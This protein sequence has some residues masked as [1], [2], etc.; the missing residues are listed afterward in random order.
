M[1]Q[2]NRQIL[3]VI[4]SLFALYSQWTSNKDL[5]KARQVEYQKLQRKFRK[6][7]KDVE[8]MAA[9]VKEAE[10]K[11]LGHLHCKVDSTARPVQLSQAASVI[12]AST[13]SSLPSTDG[14]QSEAD[15]KPGILADLSAD[16]ADG[17]GRI[18]TTKNETNCPEQRCDNEP[19]STVTT[20]P[21]IVP[22]DNVNLAP[23]SND[24]KES[25]MLYLSF[26]R[27]PPLTSHVT[28]IDDIAANVE[29]AKTA[30]KQ[31]KERADLVSIQSKE[32]KLLE[33]REDDMSSSLRRWFLRVRSLVLLPSK[34]SLAEA[35]RPVFGKLV[36][37]PMVSVITDAHRLGISDLPDVHTMIN[38]FKCLSW[39]LSTLEVIGRK[40]SISEISALVAMVSGFKLPDEKALKTLK[41]MLSRATQLQARIVKAV[42]SKP[43]ET[44]T[45]QIPFLMELDASSDEV[46]LIIPEKQVLKAAINDNGKNSSKG[47]S[48]KQEE[49]SCCREV[50]PHAPDHVKLWPPFGVLGSQAALEALGKECSAIPDE[51]C[52]LVILDQK[53]SE[54]HRGDAVVTPSLEPATPTVQNESPGV[55]ISSQTTS[56]NQIQVA[57]SAENSVSG[58]QQLAVVDHEVVM[59]TVESTERTGG[60]L[61]GPSLDTA[62]PSPTIEIASWKAPPVAITAPLVN[63]CRDG[64]ISSTQLTSLSSDIEEAA[65]DIQERDYIPGIVETLPS[66]AE[67]GIVFQ[68]QADFHK[69]THVANGIAVEDG[70]M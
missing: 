50:S 10:R 28:R 52:E 6:E 8:K 42:V 69:L 53:I 16:E 56:P 51:T 37:P 64:E 4:D 15:S 68:Q 5:K 13:S 35:A 70:T 36:S 9:A 14:N 7:R 44:K 1:R 66:D 23:E 47:L 43:G 11:L 40:P 31:A 17:T 61:P 49:N 48:L 2:P 58:V 32:R 12:T 3:K 30:L 21:G 60:A 62:D 67:Q 29:K 57:N 39:S 65:S 20:P 24:G 19:T 41:F 46:P 55:V 25:R 22:S 18:I 63:G 38:C 59:N 34:E 54:Q 33:A 26:G 27:D 45:A